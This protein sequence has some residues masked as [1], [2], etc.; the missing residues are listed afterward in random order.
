ME[1]YINKIKYKIILNKNYNNIEEIITDG[2]IKNRLK[3]NNINKISNLIELT[4]KELLKI[5]NFGKLRIKN[6]KETLNEKNIIFL[7]NPE[8][9]KKMLLKDNAG[10]I[11]PNKITKKPLEHIKEEII[12]KRKNMYNIK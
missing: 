3:G 12:K 4:D 8:Q 2:T 6:L 11:A 1:N 10:I 5:N 9:I 7:D